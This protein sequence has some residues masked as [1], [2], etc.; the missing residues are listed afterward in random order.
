[1]ICS[2]PFLTLAKT[3]ARIN[4]VADLPLAIVDHPVGGMV[5]GVIRE[6]VAQALPQVL[7]QIKATFDL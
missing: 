5:E 3:Q 2:K 4:G 1:M 6:R 7:A